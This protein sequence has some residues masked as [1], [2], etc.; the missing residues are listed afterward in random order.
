MLVVFCFIGPFLHLCEE[1]W[2]EP[3]LWEDNLFVEGKSGGVV[4][5]WENQF[6]PPSIVSS[7]EV[8]PPTPHFFPL[9]QV[10]PP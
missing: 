3:T 10:F 8:S 9:P 1:N 7:L 5:W 6:H 4:N 2:W